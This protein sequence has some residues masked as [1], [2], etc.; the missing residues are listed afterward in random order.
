MTSCTV[1]PDP[2]LADILEGRFRPGFFTGVCT[3][4]MK[5][6]SCV[7]PRVAV[8]GKKD[9][10][11]LMVIRHMVRE[12]ALPIEVVAGETAEVAIT[13]PEIRGPVAIDY[14]AQ[15]R[16]ARFGAVH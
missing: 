6:F 3:V 9:Y 7:Q 4:V 5:L 16:F 1:R 8:F 14:D 12:L 13:I 2:A 10:Q 11:Q 15:F